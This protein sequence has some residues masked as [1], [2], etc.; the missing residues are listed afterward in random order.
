MSA[1]RQ[2][3]ESTIS[4]LT[5][6]L[7]AAIVG[8]VLA[9][10]CGSAPTESPSPSTP[11]ATPN[12]AALEICRR[13]A[14]EG[15][16]TLA[17]WINGQIVAT[18]RH[19]PCVFE[20]ASGGWVG[21]G[22]RR[23]APFVT[24]GFTLAGSLDPGLLTILA[25]GR[26]P[27]E[28]TLP[29][30]AND[31]AA[32]GSRLSPMPAGGYVFDL[33][34]ELAVVSKDGTLSTS[35]LPAGYIVVGATSDPRQFVLRHDDRESAPEKMSGPY[36]VVLWRTGDQEPTAMPLLADALAATDPPNLVGCRTTRLVGG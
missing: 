17:G 25:L 2:P 28:I 26:E 24:D 30:W 20:A 13:D 19:G 3:K 15:N 23:A 7:V 10:S 31:W 6:L 32:W 9:A 29:S 22:P 8:A 33:V 5:R 34:P 27:R 4:P 14:D 12:P 36:P 16:P 35:A 21:V 18:F 11:P 1:S